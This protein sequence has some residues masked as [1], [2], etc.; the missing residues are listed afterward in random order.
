MASIA[1]APSEAR[2]ALAEECVA[3]FDEVLGQEQRRLE[4]AFLFQR[5]V[6]ALAEH[7]L[8]QGHRRRRL[9]GEELRLLQRGRQRM[10]LGHHM[11][12]QADALG[13]VAVIWL[14]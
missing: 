14:W 1:Q 13:F 6:E 3:A 7:L 12:H 5:A 10:A 8:G 9:L 4:M 11:V 2:R